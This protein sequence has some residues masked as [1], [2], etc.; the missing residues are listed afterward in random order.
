MGLTDDNPV[1]DLE[2]HTVAL[3]EKDGVG[4]VATLL[5]TLG[6]EDVLKDPLP[7]SPSVFGTEGVWVPLGEG[8]E[9]REGDWLPV[10]EGD[11]EEE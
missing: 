9:D 7:V 5:E 6:V 11:P 2:L 10:M 8:L 3:K 4:V 1:R